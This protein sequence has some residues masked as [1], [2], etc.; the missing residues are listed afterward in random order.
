MSDASDYRE[1]LTALADGIHATT[2]PTRREPR[3]SDTT[4]VLASAGLIRWSGAPKD[5]GWTPTAS[6]R[7]IINHFRRKQ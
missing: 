3:A 6:G 4:A 5:P 2:D 7:R 1:Y